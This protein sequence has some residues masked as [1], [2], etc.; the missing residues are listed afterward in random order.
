MGTWD[1]W[2]VA[3]GSSTVDYAATG[4]GIGFVAVATSD[5][6]RFSVGSGFQGLY[7]G[8]LSYGGYPGPNGEF[9]PA[10]NNYTNYSGV[11]GTGVYVTGVAGTSTNSVGVYGQTEEDP[12]SSIP[13]NISAGVFGAANTGSGVFGWST[14]WNGVEGWAYQGTAVLGVSENGYGVH[15]AST[16]QPG[17]LGWS[18]NDTGVVGGSGPEGTQGPAVPNTPNTAGVVGTSDRQHGVIGT[19]N[20]KIGVIG[21]S[22]KNIGVLGYTRAGA[23]AGFFQGNLGVT[24]TKAAVVP[25]PDGTH[26]ALYCVESPELWFEDFGTAKLKRGRTVVPLDADFAKVITR[27]DYKVFCT[28]EGDCRGLYIHRKG[29]AGFEVRELMGGK[30]SITFSY[31]I[32]GRRKDIKGQRRFAKI[33]MALP[34]PGAPPRRPA[35]T[36]AARRAFTARLENQ[37]RQGKPAQGRA[38]MT[39][40]IGKKHRPDFAR[41]LQQVPERPK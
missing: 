38:E 39:A 15:G 1:D 16:W 9:G 32:V 11:L 25:F 22:T 2:Y 4:T 35:P 26:R 28:P 36:S 12:N 33:E 30:A 34:A 27:G 14:T 20:E 41:L 19:T 18:T 23:F 8:V 40:R 6:P 3:D 13:K 24:G 31:R 37:T 10:S 21:Y 29:A 7:Y 17:A 5:E